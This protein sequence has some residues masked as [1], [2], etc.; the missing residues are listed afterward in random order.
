MKKIL[1]IV[2]GL[3][4]AL[5]ANALNITW[6]GDTSEDFGT[7][8]NWSNNS[9][10]GEADNIWMQA[11]G[12]GITTISDAQRVNSLHVR[13]GHTFNIEMGTAD[14]LV[15]DFAFRIGEDSTIGGSTVSMT[16]GTVTVGSVFSMSSDA[17]ASEC[18]TSSFTISG[19]SLTADTLTVGTGAAATFAIDGSDATVSFT[20]AMLAGANS[21]FE[22]TLGAAGIDAIDSTGV[23]TV[24]SG[25]NLVVDGAAYTGG[26]GTSVTLFDAASMTGTFAYS[27]VGMGV[28]GT[29]W[30][31]TQGTNGDVVLNVIPE[32][33]TIGM[34][35]LGALITL[36]IRRMQ[37]S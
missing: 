23:L 26:N 13:D 7:A 2:L 5:A 15:S 4:F 6:D 22:F 17:T 24:I 29:D 27:V 21:T 1:G 35:G 25:A 20:G 37:R 9:V 10:P 32:P 14:T 8:A 34:L 28:E 3:G 30:T 31:I 18:Q 11:G 12:T 19:G 33:A 16:S 36:L